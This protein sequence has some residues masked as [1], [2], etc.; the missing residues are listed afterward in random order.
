VRKVPP[1]SGRPAAVCRKVSCAR[2]DGR[3]SRQFGW[4]RTATT[5]RLRRSRKRC[6]SWRGSSKPQQ[7]AGERSTRSV[8]TGLSA[9]RSLVP[10]ST[11][12]GVPRERGSFRLM[13]LQARPVIFLG[14][15]FRPGL[16]LRI[17]DA[18]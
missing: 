14:T 8:V 3:S 17:H 11:R 15:R 7:P 18:Q 4:T 12:G 2:L 5:M 6:S 10:T 13:V 16:A 1:G 9:C